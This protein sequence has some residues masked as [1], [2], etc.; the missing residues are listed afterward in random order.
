MSLFGFFGSWAIVL[1]QSCVL[2]VAGGAAPG[3]DR[4]AAA[5]QPGGAHV[6]AGFRHARH[7]QRQDRAHQEDLHRYNCESVTS[8]ML[9]RSL[10][11]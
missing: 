10:F 11:C 6:A 9:L 3:A 8:L 4:H 7:V 5:E 1:G 2:C